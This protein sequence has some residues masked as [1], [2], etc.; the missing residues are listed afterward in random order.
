MVMV[1]VVVMIMTVA[2]LD[3]HL[4]THWSCQRC[5]EQQQQEAQTKFLH[6]Y[7][8]LSFLSLL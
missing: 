1:V 3:D 5:E 4:R 6:P 2:N 7:T 8:M